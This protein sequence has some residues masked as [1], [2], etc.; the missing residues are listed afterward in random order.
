MTKFIVRVELHKQKDLAHPDYTALHNAMQKEGF[1]RKIYGSDS[2][3]YQLPT[4]EYVIEGNYTLN[5]IHDRAKTAADSVDKSNGIIV[6]EVIGF[7]WSGL[8]AI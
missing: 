1:A 7:M 6:A 3:W 8:K 4:A 2:V 5:A